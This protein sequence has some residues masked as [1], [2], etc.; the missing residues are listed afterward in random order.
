M[1]DKLAVYICTGYGIGDALDIEALQKVAGEEMKA[2]VVKTIPSCGSDDLAQVRK[3]IESEGI[4]R[5]VIAGPTPRFYPKDAFSEDVIVDYCNIR[6][7]VVW[8]Q[9]PGEE[10]TQ[11]L[12]EDYLRMSIAKAIRMQLPDRFYVEG[13]EFNKDILVVGGGITGL[14]AALEVARTGYKVYLVEKEAELGGW[15]KKLYKTIPHNPPYEQAEDPEAEIQELIDQVNSNDNITVFTG[16]K[17]ESITGGP[18]MFDVQLAGQQPFRVGSIIQSTGWR[19]AEPTH[20]EHLGFKKIPDVVTSVDFE[21][22]AKSGKIARPSDNQPP[23]SVLFVQNEGSNEPDQFSY[24][25]SINSLNAIKQAGYVREKNPSAKAFVVYDHFKAP[26]HNELFYKAAQQDPGIFLTKGNVVSVEKENGHLKALVDDTLLGENIELDVD[27]LVLGV[28]MYPNAADGERIRIYNDSKALVEKGEEGAQ[29]EDAKKKLEEYKDYAG[30]ELLHLGY[31][32]GP[33]LPALWWGYP[34]SHFICFPYESRRT[35]IYPCGAVRSPMD[36]QG[37]IEDATGAALKAIQCVEMTS[38]GEAVHPR[39]GDNSY[40]EFNLSKCTQCKRCTEECP[41]GVLNEDVKGTPL[42]NTTRC[43]RCGVC[44]GACPERI[45]SFKD[46]S[47]D[48]VA[49][50]IR[51]VE[52]P[53]EFEEK[54]R[55]LI[56]ACENDAY[57]ALDMVGLRGGKI[58]PYVRVIPVRCLGSVN[59]IWVNEALSKGYDGILLFGCKYGDDYQ[60]HFTKGSEMMVARSDNVREKLNTMALEDERVQLFQIEIHDY[61]RLPK[62]IDEFMETID[63]VGLNPFKG[64]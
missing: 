27:M 43:R 28:G 33:D 42:P 35:G 48:M 57:P 11:M 6:E 56:L 34:D 24:S 51:S 16:A 25:S 53:D 63:D 30:T 21:A 49:N 3:D 17:I 32:Q 29:L 9:P 18:C 1:E 40:P 58:N 8:C 60:C 47:V 7:Q 38:R 15:Y 52:V 39:A 13:E 61:E 45:I 64:M 44:M 54:P 37:S 20:L 10:D 31:R 62:I 26:G 59:I 23:K 50:M 46:Y 2:P 12:A 4:T 5:L 22:M 36:A 14:T 41:F 19:P 55:V